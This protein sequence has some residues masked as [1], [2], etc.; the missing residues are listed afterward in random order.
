MPQTAGAEKSDDEYLRE[1]CEAGLLRRYGEERVR[2]D[3]SLRERFEY[4]LG[5]ITKMGFSSYFLI[6]WDFVKYARDHDIPVG[7]GR[8]SAVGSLVAYCLAITDLDPLR[9]NLFFE[10]FLNPDRISMPDIDTDFCVDRRDEVIAYVTEKYGKE[11]VAQIVTFGTMAA[12]AAIRDAGRALGVPLPDVDRVAKL[13]P[14]GPGGL[15]IAKALEQIGELK[16]L[17]S[18]RPEIRKLLDTAKEIEGLARNAG[19]HAAGV[20]ICAG[21]LM[22][23]T[24]LVRFNEGGVNTQYDMKWVEK[25]GLLKMDFLGLRNL[26]VMDNALKEIRRTTH[27]DF[28]LSQIP[29]DDA[30]TFEML[31]RGETMGIFQLESDGMQRVCARSCSRLVSKDII[32]L[33]ALYRPGPME[34]DTYFTS[35]LST[36]ARRLPYLHPKLEPILAE[37]YR[38]R[39]LSEARSCKSRATSPVSAW[40]R[41]T[42]CAK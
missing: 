36:A 32:A 22:E 10:R 37:T 35:P 34:A 33:V 31:G 17:Y 26:T 24:P 20:V 29:I 18:T 42:N 11:R 19:T 25:I 1:V 40:P 28:D 3:P 30:R 14:S 13:I 38:D 4:E 27:P 23:Y 6:V 9:F 21:P 12:R 41:P 5:V 16:A 39:L 15:T 2:T 7:P 8:G